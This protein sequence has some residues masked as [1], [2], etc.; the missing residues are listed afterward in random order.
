M[1]VGFLERLGVAPGE[2]TALVSAGSDDAT[3]VAELDR[4]TTPR[5]RTAAN[6]W[7]LKEKA[8]SLDR[9]DHEEGR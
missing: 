7:I 5:R 3:L 1:D 8:A 6:R 9:Q 4:R 2:F